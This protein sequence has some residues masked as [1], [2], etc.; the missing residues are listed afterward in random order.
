MTT[1]ASLSHVRSSGEDRVRHHLVSSSHRS[2]CAGSLPPDRHHAVDA[3]AALA[4]GVL[5]RHDRRRGDVDT[6]GVTCVGP[7]AKSGGRTS[8]AARLA[9]QTTVPP[10]I[11]FAN[12]EYLYDTNSQDPANPRWVAT[13]DFNGDGKQDIAV[14]DTWPNDGTNHLRIELGNG[15]GGFTEAASYSLPNGM[16][17]IA[18]ADLNRDGKPDIVVGQGSAGVAVFLNTGAGTFSGPTLYSIPTPSG[19][20]SAPSV[21]GLA[22]ADLTG[23]GVPDIVTG[24]GAINFSGYGHT[25][26]VYSVIM[27]NGDGTFQAAQSYGPVIPNNPANGGGYPMNGIALGNLNGKV[28]MVVAAGANTYDGPAGFEWLLGNG[29]GTFT[30]NGNDFASVGN[31]YQSA[32]NVTLAD[33][34]GDGHLDVAV[35]DQGCGYADG[36][37]TQIFLGDGAGGFTAGQNLQDNCV[38][39]DQVATDL[40]G[41]GVTDLVV[42][43]GRQSQGYLYGDTYFHVFVGNGDGTFTDAGRSPIAP[44]YGTYGVAAG[45][46][47]GDGRPDLVAANGGDSV[48]GESHDLTIAL[49]TS[50]KAPIGGAIKNTEVPGGFCAAC[51]AATQ[52]E[53]SK[54]V[55]TGTGDFWHNFTDLSIPGR[56]IPLAFSHTYNEVDAATSGPLGYG[57]TFPYNTSLSINQTTGAVTV[58]EETGAQEAFTPSGSAYTAPPRVIAT[59]VKNADGTYTL[60][61]RSRTSYTFSSIGAL[62]SEKDLNGYIT[63]LAYNGS[64]QLA[65]VTDP[66]GRS[67]TLSY[68]GGHL[69]SVSDPLGRQVTFQYNDGNGNLTDVYDV[70]GGLTHF[71]YDSSH[72][73]L[74]MTDPRG[75]LL[76]NSYDAQGRVYQQVSSQTST[77]NLTTTFAYTGNPQLDGT[78]TI[79]D[80]SGNV[81]VDTYYYGERVAV[82]KGSGT[83]SAATWVYGYDP[84]TVGVTA[85][86]DPDGN[87]TQASYDAAGDVLSQTDALQRQTVNTYDSLNDLKTSKDPNGV[88]T[89]YTYDGSGN[90]QSTSRPLVGSSPAQTQVTTY[91]YGDPSHPGDVTSKLDA[92]GKTWSYG[93]DQ[94]GDLTSATDPLHNTAT[95]TYNTVGWKLTSISPRGNVTGCGCASQYTTTYGYVDTISGKTNEDGLVATVTD[96]LGHIT[97]NHYDADRNLTSSTDP[98]GKTTS[99]TYDLANE[100]TVVT[101]ADSTTLQTDYN[102]NG[103]VLDEKDGKGNV[104]IAYEYDPLARVVSTQDGLE[105]GST[106]TVGSGN[107]PCTQFAYDP[108]GNLISKTDPGG[109]CSGSPATGCT[110][111]C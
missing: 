61:V 90:L 2:R 7:L 26:G 93:Y 20:T 58:N 53:T 105:A 23:S 70:N 27:G 99:S 87:T 1:R 30:Y 80:P 111:M 45:D 73:L 97:A 50:P 32:E 94:Y 21:D 18:V 88:T 47:N 8:P 13:G 76:T 98:N 39:G 6:G 43:S 19:G 101:R 79:T 91:N 46:F 29:D 37:D 52:G 78:T 41:D 10:L 17:R 100:K 110:T 85:V 55:D 48:N 81:E 103:T 56:G 84:A 82:T 4:S 64:G 16:G 86:T 109:N 83:S 107:Q 28:G 74:T 34:N 72:R 9:S 108:A 63:S 5:G 92:D 89:T 96:P 51:A 49:N 95:A 11:S 31:Y 33:F 22:V 15:S 57:W 12:S 3:A 40:N 60:T 75:S 36:N 25:E 14:V 65:T 24:D 66:A 102:P 68:S 42:I 62:V 69:A 71:S 44:G 35:S 59:L 106:C 67:L 104:V 54:P 77:V 38:L